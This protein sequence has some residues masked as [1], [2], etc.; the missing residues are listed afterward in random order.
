MSFTG[1]SDTEIVEVMIFGDSV[2]YG[3]WDNNGGWVQKLRE[4]FDV[5]NLVDDRVAYFIYNLGIIDDTT[6]G[7]VKRFKSEMESRKYL[8][9]VQKKLVIFNIGLN[10]SEILL[11][12]NTNRI[13]KKQFIK[14]VNALIDM[15]RK[16]ADEVVCMGPTPVNEKEAEPVPWDEV[17]AYKNRTVKEYD[18][19]LQTICKRRKVFFI[20]VFDKFMQV[21]YLSLLEDGLHPNPAGHFVLHEIAKDFLEKN[22]ILKFG[23]LKKQR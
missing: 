1:M 8:N 5:W 23:A 17:K 13:P 19:I 15:A 21:D 2:T 10:D 7:I 16:Y 9:E 3:V 6:T 4:H 14:N 22:N 11:K 18:S 20:E 12:D